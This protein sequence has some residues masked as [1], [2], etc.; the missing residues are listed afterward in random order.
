MSEVKNNFNIQENKQI[1]K[2]S[3]L[4]EIISSII[5]KVLSENNPKEAPTRPAPETL[6]KP[7]T[8]SPRPKRRT[9]QPPTESPDTKPKA[10]KIKESDKDI[11]NKIA[12]RFKKLSNNG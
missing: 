7:D 1:M 10:K 8:D 11:A 12:N 2:K 4:K 9:L 3:K 6:P 5:E